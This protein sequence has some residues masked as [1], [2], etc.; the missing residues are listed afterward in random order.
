MKKHNRRVVAVILAI[1]LTAALVLPLLLEAVYA[2]DTKGSGSAESVSAAS[3]AESDP[4][5]SSGSGSA[6]GSAAEGS[7]SDLA[8]MDGVYIENVNVS[9]MT[10][11][12]VQA[13]VDSK[14]EA[15]SADLIT[16]YAGSQ[17]AQVTAGDLGLYSTNTG[18]AEEAVSIGRKGNV[19]K[20]FLADQYMQQNGRI[21]LPLKLGVKESMVRDAVNQCLGALESDPKPA[22]IDIGSDGTLTKADKV[23]GVKVDV[24]KSVGLV[25]N[26]MSSEWH[27][28]AGGVRLSYTSVPASGDLSEL[29]GITDQL[30]TYTTKFDP[31]NT[32]R[33]T[34]IRRAVELIN[35]TVI[36]PGEEFDF[37]KVVGETT[38]E[39]GFELAGSYENGTVVDTYGGG[40]CQVST[41]LYNAVL[42]AELDV[43]ERHPHSIT[44]NYVDPSL[45]A[46]IADGSK[47]FRFQN[48]LDHAI[49]LYAKADETSLTFAVLGKETRDPQRT[50]KFE[51]RT[52]STTPYTT[53][54][55]LDSSRNYGVIESSGG[56][57]GIEAQAWKIVYVNG[58]KQ[59][60]EQVNESDYNMSPLTYL[61]GI[62]GANESQLS[63]L[64]SA[65]ANNDISA[66][67][68]LVW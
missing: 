61:V 22:S 27:G 46:A 10:V 68:S 60:E 50:L 32:G 4:S 7:S 8:C 58:V 28:G 25:S 36:Q 39:N 42:R 11:D 15:L 43:T 9:G 6:S 31:T 1:I 20:R 55:K 19:V 12:E 44:V 2:A 38:A 66:I 57:D 14:I 37:S 34:N 47:N 23:D 62:K 5:G 49:Y 33:V 52:V 24:S 54:V 65:A 40:I 35:G 26:Y 3:S 18:L 48:N 17:S 16:F 51:S 45:D 53:A 29:D 13:V 64:Q 41:T 56:H 59:S 63:A 30:G 21:V 67:R